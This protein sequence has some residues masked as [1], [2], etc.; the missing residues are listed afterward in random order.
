M[1]RTTLPAARSVLWPILADPGTVTMRGC[2]VAPA[3]ASGCV[4]HEAIL[5]P[6]DRPDGVRARAQHNFGRC[7]S[8]I[9]KERQTRFKNASC[10]GLLKSQEPKR[11]CSRRR[12]RKSQGRQSFCTVIQP[13][14]RFFWS[15]SRGASAPA[16]LLLGLPLSRAVA[17]GSHL[18]SLEN[19][20]CGRLIAHP[21]RHRPRVASFARVRPPQAFPS[22]SDA[23]PLAAGWPVVCRA[24]CLLAIYSFQSLTIISACS[25][26]SQFHPVVMFRFLLAQHSCRPLLRL[27]CA[28]GV[29]GW[30]PPCRRHHERGRQGLRR[31][32]GHP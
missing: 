14:M 19:I 9:K 27:Q 26:A 32:R 3:T 13:R 24:L 15:L 2:G 23:A 1:L 8:V 7:D 25:F 10:R 28:G 16:S 4:E 18:N 5:V 22:K 11:L 20:L 31:W 6:I 30:P 17:D 29:Q 12:A 21:C